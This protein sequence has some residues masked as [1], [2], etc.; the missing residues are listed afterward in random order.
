MANA[1][2]LYSGAIGINNK[3]SP[4]RLK[5]DPE[6]GVAAL[7]SA[8][9][10]LI[11][12]SGEIVAR[13]GM[14]ESESGAYHSLYPAFEGGLVVRDRDSDSALYAISVDSNGN[15]ELSGIRSGLT[16]GARMDY[17]TTP[18]GICYTNGYQNGMVGSDLASSPWT[19]SEWEDR[20]TT[21]GFLAT[22][23]SSHIGYLAG[24]VYFFIGNVLGYT[25]FGKS[26][27]YDPAING[28]QFPSKGLMI[29]PTVDGLYVSDTQ[30]IY[31]LTGLDPHQWSSRKITDYPALEWGVSHKPVDPS[32]FGFETNVP[33]HII[34][35]K[36]GPAMCL[37]SGNLINLIDKN[38]T[39]PDCPNLGA[40]AVFDET[41]IIQ[42]GS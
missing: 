15:T 34:A 8:N 25:E 14:V 41:L 5:Y 17:C 1:R 7:E 9:D 33:S 28:E 37:P 24:R 21:A 30:S 38:I 16:K 32:F 36:R 31:F 20:E 10:V 35:T 13:R 2:P 6:L 22:P 19:E 18:L 26:G 4:H 12:R 3:V 40:L 42:S 27:I 23:V 11:D 39:M 29:V